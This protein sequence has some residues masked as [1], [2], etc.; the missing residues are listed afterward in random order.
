MWF[1]EYA[2]SYILLNYLLVKAFLTIHDLNV[3]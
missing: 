1:S 2:F 3:F